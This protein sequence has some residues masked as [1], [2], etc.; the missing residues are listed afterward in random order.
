MLNTN[1][2]TVYY[3]TPSLAAKELVESISWSTQMC[4]IQ[5]TRKYDYN[6]CEYYY[7]A[8]DKEYKEKYYLYAD[9]PIIGNLLQVVSDK[10]KLN[11]EYDETLFK[12][13]LADLVE[14]IYKAEDKKLPVKTSESYYDTYDYG[15]FPYK[16]Y[17]EKK[18]EKAADQ[19][20]KVEPTMNWEY[21]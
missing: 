1:Y 3:N 8:E 19:L 10:D 20:S 4:M 14:Q 17:K 12:D 15:T 11:Y 16:S 5:W 6:L 18:M 21:L 13:E 9:S 7:F 2:K